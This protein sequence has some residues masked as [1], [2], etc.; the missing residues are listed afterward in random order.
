MS[1]PDGVQLKYD[2]SLAATQHDGTRRARVRMRVY[3][4]LGPRRAFSAASTLS[5]IPIRVELSATSSHLRRHCNLPSVYRGD[6]Q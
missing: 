5:S 3:N 6:C 4:P 1:K 2:R